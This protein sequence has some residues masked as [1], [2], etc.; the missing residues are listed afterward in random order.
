[1]EWRRLL[2]DTLRILAV[3]AAY[4]ATGRI[5]LQLRVIV[6]GAEV[7]PLWAPT[8]IAVAAL[9]WWGLRVWPGITLGAYLSIE[10]I[11]TFQPA[12][13]GLLVGNT[14]APVCAYLMLRRVGFRPEMDRLRDGLA[15][16]FLGG[17]LPMLI[18]AT[19]GAAT[20]EA[21][22]DLPPDQFWSV[23]AAW[24]TGDAMGVLLVTPVLLVLPR[25]RRPEDPLRAAEAAALFAGCAAVT[26]FAARSSLSL[27]FLVFPM[28]IW[29]AVRF[30]HSVGAPCALLVSVLAIWAAIDQAGPFARHSLFDVMVN[31]QGL[32]G[33]AALTVLLLSALVTEQNNIRL[34]IEQLC[35]E[36]AEVVDRLAPGRPDEQGEGRGRSEGGG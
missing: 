34:K 25:L 4:Y 20:L 19:I 31:L 2:A 3:A 27:L 30:Q 36:L 24:W 12:D 13:L 10:H 17:L 35:D 21:T 33:S 23:W 5:G 18:S 26:V 8:G 9:L 7:T 14:L 6:G 29:V 28:L 1:M 16:V 11:S 22:G 15:L 32:N